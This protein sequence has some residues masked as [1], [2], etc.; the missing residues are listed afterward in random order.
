MRF[1]GL[2]LCDLNFRQL[3]KHK[4]RILNFMNK[5]VN[6]KLAHQLGDAVEFRIGTVR[7]QIKASDCD[8]L[9][10]R[11]TSFPPVWK[12]LDMYEDTD[13]SK[14]SSVSTQGDTEIVDETLKSLEE[15]F[16]I[17]FRKKELNLNIKQFNGVFHLCLCYLKGFNSVVRCCAMFLYIVKYKYPWLDYM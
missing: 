13:L 3:L 15:Q 1:P 6:S 17:F 16:T 14:I 11:G 4:E 9:V 7:V 10:I 2:I 5:E 12:N 8:V